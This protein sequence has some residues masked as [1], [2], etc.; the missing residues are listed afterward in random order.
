MAHPRMYDQDDPFLLKVRTL[1]L[2]FPESFEKETFG[3]PTFRCGRIFAYYGQG[4]SGTPREHSVAI[5]PDIGERDALLADDRFYVPS[6]IGAYGWL[7]LDLEAAAPDWQE[8]AELLDGSYRRIAPS[9]CLE[10]IQRDGSPAT[11]RP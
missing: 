5:L 3:R 1:C 11:R 9:R 10:A 6:Y 7:G 4:Q 2:A 8:V